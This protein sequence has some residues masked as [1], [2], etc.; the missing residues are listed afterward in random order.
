MQLERDNGDSVY[1]E[2]INQEHWCKNQFQ[3]TNQVTMEGSYKNRYDVTLLINGLP[4]S[5]KVMT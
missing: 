4:D 2:F 1:L 3:V 5:D